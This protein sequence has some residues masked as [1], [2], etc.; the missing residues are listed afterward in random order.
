MRMWGERIEV[1]PPS[2]MTNE[3]LSGHRQKELRKTRVMCHSSHTA[4][5]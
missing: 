5:H 3:K 1:S 2:E 4:H